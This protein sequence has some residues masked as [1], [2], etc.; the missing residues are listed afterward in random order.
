M[1]G[2]TT[3][4]VVERARSILSNSE[5]R[6]ILLPDDQCEIHHNLHLKDGSLEH[7]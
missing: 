4:K 5:Y 3:D 6:L 1:I 7:R 2:A